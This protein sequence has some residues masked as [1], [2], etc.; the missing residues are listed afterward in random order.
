MSARRGGRARWAD[1]Q[2]E[3]DM[4]RHLRRVSMRFGLVGPALVAAVFAASLVAAPPSGAS[5]TAPAQSTA[6]AAVRT[7]KLGMRGP[8]VRAL[9]QRLLALHYFPGPID[10]IFGQYT[11][12]A[13]WAFQE[14]QGMHVTGEVG[15]PTRQALADPRPPRVLAPHGGNLRVE[16]NLRARVLV[17]YRSGKVALISHVSTGGGYYYC[18]PSGCGYAVTPTGNFRTTVFMPGWVTV[19]LGRMYNPV[20]FIRRSYAIHGS[21]SVPL[22]PVSHGCVRIPMDI[23]QFFHKLVPTPG[24]PVYIRQHG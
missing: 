3:V 13:V 5:P 2:R 10:G 15:P 18:S 22:R 12:E 20:F 17:L 24:T 11:L 23:A 8:D 7:L 1:A 16:I 14:V 4:F 9:Q 21:E 6:A 19:P